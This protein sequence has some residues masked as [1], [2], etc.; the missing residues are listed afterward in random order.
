MDNEPEN[1]KILQT[2]IL[3]LKHLLNEL[4][5]FNDLSRAMSS[6]MEV[7]EIMATI[8]TKSIQ[9]IGV[10]QGNIMLMNKQLQ[11]EYDYDKV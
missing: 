7:Q 10:E 11:H 2:E 6:T 3:R 8:I 9:T 5:I 4:T 1:I